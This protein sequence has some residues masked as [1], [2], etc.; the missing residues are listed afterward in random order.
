MATPRILHSDSVACI[1]TWQN[2][3]VSVIAGDMDLAGMQLL[4]RTCRDTRAAYPSGIVTFAILEAQ[5]PVGSKAVRDE[6]SKLVKEIGGSILRMAIVLEANGLMAQVLRTVIRGLNVVARNMKLVM[7]E[8]VTEA[9]RSLAPFVVR[10]GLTGDAALELAGA[11][12]EI[13]AGYASAGSSYG[14]AR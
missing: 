12:R 7:F 1:A 13:R 10:A 14:A 2:V 9:S 5:V 4:A 3:V 6:A 8:S 11:I